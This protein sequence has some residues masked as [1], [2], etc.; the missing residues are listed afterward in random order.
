MNSYTIPRTWGLQRM[1]RAVTTYRLPLNYGAPSYLKAP[2]HPST[3]HV[4]KET[5]HVK[6]PNMARGG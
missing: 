1:N 4:Y 2:M 6:G 5:T 3:T